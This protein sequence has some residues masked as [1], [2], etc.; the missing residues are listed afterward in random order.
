MAAL[1]SP[2]DVSRFSADPQPLRH[3]I[4]TH[5]LPRSRQQAT[6][7]NYRDISTTH[8][9]LDWTVD[10]QQRILRGAV[11]HHLVAKTDNVRK[12]I[13]D[14]SYL[15]IQRCFLRSASSDDQG[16][17][18]KD[19]EFSLPAKRHPVLGSPLTISLPRPLARGDALRLVIE[20]ATTDEC[21]ALGWLNASQTDSKRYPFVYSQCQAIH[22]RSMI[23]LFDTPA[24]KATYS[25]RVRSTLPVLLSA[26]RTSPPLEDGVPEIDGRE[27]QYEY[28]QPIAIPSY[29]IAIAGGEL[30]FRSLGERTGIWAEPG[31]IERCEYEF[32]EDAERM[33]RTAEELCGPYRWG[34]YDAL[35]LPSSF[36]Y[37]G[38]EI[39]Q[40]TFLTP[41]L[42]VGDRSQVDVVAH[43]ASHSWHVSPVLRLPLLFPLPLTDT[44]NTTDSSPTTHRATTFHATA[45][46][47]SG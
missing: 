5:P 30:A 46:T 18:T 47:A 22:A 28:D 1:P 31:M 38:M 34:R 45:G 29:L 26:R 32:R 41:A 11:T 21:T 44:P 33:V 20:Y 25:A 40:I 3:H 19:L 13:L 39:P 43:E 16:D 17:S 23:P 2:V 4:P 8:L 36:P 14:S 15:T 10:W 37:G 24:V 35:V 42:I 12:V 27:H 6:Q 9:E 7:S